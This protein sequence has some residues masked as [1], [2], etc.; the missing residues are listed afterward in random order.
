MK[1]SDK[2]YKIIYVDPPWRFKNWSMEELAKRGEKWARKN[3]RSPYSVMDT[4]DICKLP[5]KDI[6]DKD[7]VLFMWVTYPKLEEAFEVIRAWGFTYKTVAFTWVKKR[8][9]GKFHLGLG[10]WTRGNPELCL[11]ATCGH[12][13]RISKKVSNLTI[14]RLR[15]HSRKPDEVRDKIVKLIG[16]VSRIELFSRDRFNG[17][18]YWGDEVPD[19]IQNDLV[20]R[21]I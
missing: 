4:S 6:A 8:K 7:C 15:E 10:Y 16:D 1:I 21:K 20:G 5:V 19:S 13:H 11:L 3:G 2:K 18:D 14:S 12:P 17:W 9:N